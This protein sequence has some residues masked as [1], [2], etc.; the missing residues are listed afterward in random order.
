MDADVDKF[1][2]YY[3]DKN[4]HPAFHSWYSP[5]Y[6][7]DFTV[8]LC[9]T[10]WIDIM[11]KGVDKGAA[12]QTLGQMLH[13]LPTQMM[14]FGDSYNDIPMLEMVKFS[15]VV[16]NASKDMRQ[17]ARFLAESNDDYGVLKVMDEIIGS[18]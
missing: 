9:D 8:T 12:M 2:V 14:A 5:V 17:H 7:E 10:S 4:C 13:I 3:P 11:N 18:R 1:T 6:G 16:K 15:Y